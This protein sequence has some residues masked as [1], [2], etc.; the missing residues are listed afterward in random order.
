M[1]N[2]KKEIIVFLRAARETAA[3]EGKI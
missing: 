1:R 3:E 2:D